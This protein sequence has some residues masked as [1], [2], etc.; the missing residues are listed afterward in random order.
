[1]NPNKINNSSVSSQNQF[2]DS[3]GQTTS[4]MKNST[5]NSTS[6]TPNIFYNSTNTSSTTEDKTLTNQNV[7]TTPNKSESNGIL[8]HHFNLKQNEISQNNFHLQDTDTGPISVLGYNQIPEPTYNS[9][10]FFRCNNT[11]ELPDNQPISVLGYNHQNEFNFN[12]VNLNQALRNNLASPHFSNHSMENNFPHW[13]FQ[14]TPIIR[15]SQL[16]LNIEQSQVLHCINRSTETN[17]TIH[18]F[19]LILDNNNETSPENTEEL[20]EDFNNIDINK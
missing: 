17:E 5:T 15:A 7:D 16:F 20:I 14:T 3:M 2:H 10:Y 8:F 12:Y 13:C 9:I 11:Q 4:R 1:M 19:N 6:Q 18:G